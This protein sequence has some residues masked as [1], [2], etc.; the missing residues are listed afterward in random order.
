MK[1]MKFAFVILLITFLAIYAQEE[2]W[3]LNPEPFKAQVILNTQDSTLQ[4]TNG[5]VE[6]TFLLQPNVAAVSFKNLQTEEEFLRA[7]RPEA[8]IWIDSLKLNIGGLTGQPVQNYLHLDWLKQL[9]VDPLSFQFVAL[10]ISETQARFPYKPRKEWLSRPVSWPPP[11]KRLSLKFVATDR[12]IAYLNAKNNPQS[13]ASRSVLFE[14]QFQQVNKHWQ[15][16]ASKGDARNSFVNEGKFG[17]IMARAHQA[18]FA[19]LKWPHQAQQII[20]KIDPGTDQSTGWGPGIALISFARKMKFYLRPAE[21]RFCLFDGQKEHYFKGFRVGKPVY[22][23]ITLNS[24]TIYFGY[25]YDAARWETVFKM[26]FDGQEPYWVRVGKTDWRGG[27]SDYTKAGPLGRCRIEL[28]KI[29]G[30]PQLSN[31]RNTPHQWDYLKKIAVYV[32]Y[33]IYDGLPVVAKWLEITNN[34]SQ[35]IRLNRFSSEILATVEAES[36]VGKPPVGW[37]L[38]N[39]TVTTDYAFGGSMNLNSAMNR[40]VFWKADPQYKTMVDY[41][42]TTPT[43]LVCQPKLGPDVNLKPGET[44]Q[45]FWTFELLHDSWER[46][47]KGLQIRR[48][49]RVLAPWTQE[50]PILMHVRSAEESAVKRAIDQCADVGFEMVI[51]TFGSGFNIENDD[52]AYLQ[53]MKELADYAHQKGIALGGYSLLASRK[54]GGGNDVVL[55]EGR[56]PVFG[57]SPCLQSEWGRNYFKKLYHFFSTTGFD[58]LEHDGSYPGDICMA[59]HH[60]G[61]RGLYDSQWQQFILIRDFYRWCRANGIYLNVPDWYFLNGSNK[62]AMGYRETNWSLPRD[63]QEIIERQNIYDGTWEKTPSMGWMFVPLVQYH[64]GGPAA[65]IEPLKEHLAHY[66]QR[67]INLFTAGVQACYRGPRLYDAPET[68]TIVK[69][70]VSFYK[71]HRRILDSD[72]IHLRRP[73]GRDWDGILHVDPQEAIKGFLV[74][75]NPLSQSIKRQ[76]TVPLYYTGLKEKA[77]VIDQEGNEKILDINRKFKVNF[78]VDLPPKSVRWWIIK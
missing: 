54:I 69:R 26:P 52:P 14:D 9:Q 1:H 17:E 34:G 40:S 8:Q 75:Y 12:L 46:E 43:L 6:R 57:N 73:D 19:E 16:Y 36:S 76:I 58:V 31:P 13:D 33:E 59:T 67:L 15:L 29:L 78:P 25:S 28:V 10:K 38:P 55:P 64:G 22:L 51:L 49:Y 50:N 35:T 62:I 74:L 72:I 47:R 18:V 5:L 48:M 42:R 71:K 3:V 56:K 65:T 68:R 70:W 66:E 11:G 32:N 44:F 60:P 41:Q 24:D 7:V 63:F 53:K 37:R 20:V 23:K 2:D 77:H 4:L 39:M 30:A 45:S 61:H 27:S 21:K